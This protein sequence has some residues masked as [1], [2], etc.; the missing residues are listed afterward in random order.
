MF[1]FQPM[2][3]VSYWP[4]DSISSLFSSSAGE[5]SA[6]VLSDSEGVKKRPHIQRFKMNRTPNCRSLQKFRN[7]AMKE[8]KGVQRQRA[9]AEG[10]ISYMIKAVLVSLVPR[11]EQQQA[12]KER[13]SY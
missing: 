12:S 11:M 6:G 13:S 10:K 2:L 9:K 8:C 4:L 5:S 3:S 1:L 7:V